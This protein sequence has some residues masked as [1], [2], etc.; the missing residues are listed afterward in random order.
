MINR[1]FGS[2][3]KGFAILEYQFTSKDI[4][5]RCQGIFGL[6]FAASMAFGQ[7]VSQD[8]IISRFDQYAKKNLQEKVYV[9]TD[10]NMY[11]TGEIMWFKIYEMGAANNSQMDFSKVVYTEIISNDQKVVLQA[12][13]GITNGSGSG[14]LQ[15]PIDLSSGTY[16][17]RSYTN[18]M[19]NFGP[20][21]FFEKS[22]YVVNT[23]LKPERAVA[24]D[25][26]NYAIQF[27][28]EGGDLVEG[29]SSKIGFKAVD[30][31]GL[32]IDFTG[33]IVD[34]NNEVIASIKPAKFG[35]GSFVMKP[36]ANR[37]YRAVI[38][39]PGGGSVTSALP[40]VK[41]NGYVM[42]VKEISGDKLNIE[43]GTNTGTSDEMLL[44]A[45]TR[46]ETK[47]TE[48]ISLRNGKADFQV[49]KSKLG[50]GISHFTLF[51]G[52]G[53]PIAERLYFKRPA[54]KLMF[55]VKPDQ[56]QYGKRK[57][58]SLDLDA[59]NEKGEQADANA[60]ISIYASNGAAPAGIDIVSYLWLK[61][62]L[63][64][65]VEEPGY[66]FRSADAQS[67]E[68]LDNL[69]LT[70]GWRRFIW[71][72]VVSNKVKKPVFLPE[73]DGHTI[74]G[75]LIDTR[76][77]AP[78][79]NIVTYLSVPGKNFQLYTARSNTNGEVTFHTR[80]VAGPSELV[81][82]TNF[83]I[84]STYRIEFKS[85]YFTEYSSYRAPSIRLTEDYRSTLLTQSVAN[86]VQ[87]VYLGNK[88]RTFYPAAIDS[89]SF[90]LK[91]ADSY[92]LDN[93]VRFNT[94]EEVLRE[95]VTKV[96]VTRQKNEFNLW[97][98]FKRH[99]DDQYV[100]VEPL[101]VYDGVPIFDR[102]TKIVR[103]DPKKV[104]SVEVLDKKYFVGP[105]SFNSII[106]FKSYKNN[107]PDFALDNRATVVDYD[108]VQL[109]REFYS[110]VYET[111]A[112]VSDRLPDFRNLL[113]WSPGVVLGSSGKKSLSFYTSDQKGKYTIVVEG[114]SSLGIPGSNVFNIEVK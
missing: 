70:Q 25:K 16:R 103:Y 112:Q 96:P 34:E 107:L 86:Q 65:Y 42:S 78:A 80:N 55:N 24:A 75:K 7:S 21:Y 23:L 46:Q 92:L 53:Q 111:E 73:I 3:M 50:D 26:V 94:M 64:G 67:T 74:E 15:L 17:I 47:I 79:S 84:D 85:P 97:V 99:Y 27:F 30:N 41:K 52:S 56:Q 9:H 72:D 69:M 14:S 18:W 19:K 11:L 33:S 36:M 1:L 87:N 113:Y 49:D 5:R 58:V 40:A 38:Q 114:I 8:S 2:E 51:N 61:S 62:D 48:K 89:G 81:A 44:I 106:N 43:I 91:P 54:A 71:D 35:I 37:N 12:K 77:N 108:G 59:L 90:Y 63:K 83:K 57:K 28:P 93:F 82:Q 109:R 98:S 66:Y 104:K 32:G 88:L 22:L 4:V 100:D 105:A 110:P 6:L 39:V 102:G 29:L 76:T 45:H 68:G 13:T 20:D 31:E 101:L 10:K 60:S 95:Y